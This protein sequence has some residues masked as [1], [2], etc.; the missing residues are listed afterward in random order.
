MT[1]FFHS[2]CDMSGHAPHMNVLFTGLLDFWVRIRHGKVG[3][4]IDWVLWS[5]R[6]SY[7]TIWT[8]FSRMWNDIL[9]LNH[10]QWHP[11]LIRLDTNSW[12]HYWTWPFNNSQRCRLIICNGFG[13]QKGRL[14]PSNAC[15]RLI[16]D[17]PRSCR[18]FPELYTSNIPWYYLD[19]TIGYKIN[20]ICEV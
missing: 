13:M 20:C 6:G 18:D 1:F 8:S 15:S 2:L 3:I 10:I 9:K 19:Y 17:F 16:S 11:P 5:I 12:H 4:V 14:T 7:Q